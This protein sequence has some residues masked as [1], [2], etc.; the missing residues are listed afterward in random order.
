[1]NKFM[2]NIPTKFLLWVKRSDM[3]RLDKEIYEGTTHLLY[4]GEN[5]LC[6]KVKDEFFYV[7][8]YSWGASGYRDGWCTSCT[9]PNVC[10]FLIE[11][12]NDLL[13]LSK[14]EDMIIEIED[15]T[16]ANSSRL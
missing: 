2:D 15:D 14:E 12:Y 4:F 3:L 1:M 5:K 16:P 10:S 7:W 8:P 13:T 6:F 11:H 9:L